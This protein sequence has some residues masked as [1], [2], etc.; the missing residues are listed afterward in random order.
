[1]KRISGLAFAA[2]LLNAACHSPQTDGGNIPITLS[3]AGVPVFNA[4]SA[5]QSVATLV[6]FGPRIPGTPVQLKAAGWLI[7]RMKV[8]A[9]TVYVQ[10]TTVTAWNKKQL[11]CFNIIGSFNP[12]AKERILLLTHWDTRPY[13]D[14]DPIKANRTKPFDGADDGGSGTAVLLEVARQLHLKRPDIGIDIL[15]VD[16]EDYGNDQVAH[17]F[18]LG[19][20][21]WAT[22]PQV[23]GYTADY[24]ILLDMVGARN[25]HF[26]MEG[27][28]RRYA[29]APM[30]MFWNT[31]NQLGY[32]DYFRYGRTRVSIEDDHQY[33]NQ[34]IHIPTFDVINL[35][36]DPD[37][38]FAAH[39]HTQQDNLSIID[40][41]TLKAVG[42]TLLQ[43]VYTHPAY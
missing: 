29:S 23:P 39:W 19:T 9:D 6:G 27:Q 35:H 2:L 18:C 4:D 11:P 31:G 34:L 30:N 25:A 17:S 15:L 41:S 16:D 21:Y 14:N 20:Q 3:T 12:S 37:N 28:S 32:S 26:L 42:Q 33:V 40:T 7:T 10:H 36:R 43:V 24:G 8:Y 22:H 5:Y 13:S 38:P 1:M